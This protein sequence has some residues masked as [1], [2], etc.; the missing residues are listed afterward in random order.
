MWSP[1]IAPVNF[2]PVHSVIW[3]CCL[4][5]LP[6]FFLLYSHSW[7]HHHHQ[8]TI[9]QLL[10]LFRFSSTLHPRLPLLLPISLIL[11]FLYSFL[12]PLSLEKHDKAFPITH[13]RLIK[14][15]RYKNLTHKA[16]TTIWRLQFAVAVFFFHFCRLQWLVT[17][18]QFNIF[19]L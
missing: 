8:P 10:F 5:W 17:F 19:I 4:C 12:L 6:N 14:D 13:N 18:W 7:P 1:V 3:I 15:V 2:C 16:F 11:Y 9:S